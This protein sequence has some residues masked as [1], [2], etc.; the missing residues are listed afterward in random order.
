MVRGP[1]PSLKDFYHPYHLVAI[2][3]ELNCSV[4]HLA[5]A[6]LAAN[7]NTSTIIL[8]ASK[9]EQV[10]ENLKALEV[11]PKLTPGIMA[12]IET[13][14]ENKPEPLVR[15]VVLLTLGND[16]HM[17]SFGCSLHTTGPRWMSSAGCRS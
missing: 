4:T 11:I 12:K 7:P 16:A 6:W 15:L 1:L 9:P 13:I 14:L 5:L 17:W 2:C 8:G 10:L 3:A